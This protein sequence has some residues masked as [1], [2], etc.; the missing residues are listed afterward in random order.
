MKH[1]AQSNSIHVI[2]QINRSNNN[3]K[4]CSFQEINQLSP[5]IPLKVPLLILNEDIW[6][7]SNSS[8]IINFIVKV[9]FC[10]FPLIEY[11]RKFNIYLFKQ[12]C[13]IKIE[14]RIYYQKQNII[15]K[16]IISNYY[17]YYAYNKFYF[18]G[19]EIKRKPK[20]EKRLV[21]TTI[22]IQTLE[23]QKYSFIFIL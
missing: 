17:S 9:Y 16:P 15:R 23:N 7:D 20:V 18:K 6:S 14:R 10:Y 5:R 3:N 12:L 13:N 8:S 1:M 19:Y 2:K 21:G 22:E 11:R 4:Q